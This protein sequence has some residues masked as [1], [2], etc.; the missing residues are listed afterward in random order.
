[1]TMITDENINQAID[2]FLLWGDKKLY[3]PVTLKISS[4]RTDDMV[5]PE[6]AFDV[7]AASTNDALKVAE[8]RIKSILKVDKLPEDLKLDVIFDRG[9]DDDAIFEVEVSGPKDLIAKL[10]ASIKG[11][12]PV[13]MAVSRLIPRTA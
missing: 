4:Y 9:E 2:E 5:D 11:K 6:D 13:D 1:M 7:A 12:S 8:D 3:F 10:S